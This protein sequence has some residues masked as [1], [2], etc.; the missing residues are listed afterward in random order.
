MG[1]GI[2]EIGEEIAPNGAPPSPIDVTDSEV[3]PKRRLR[4]CF[5]PSLSWSVLD[6]R[7]VGSDHALDQN[8]IAVLSGFAGGDDGKGGR[9]AA[10][11]GVAFQGAH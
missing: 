10:I 7:S 3:R 5:I 9:G 6:D 8:E 1:L 4:V 2:R 11:E